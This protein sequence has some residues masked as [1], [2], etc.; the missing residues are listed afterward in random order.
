MTILTENNIPYTVRE[1]HVKRISWRAILM[2]LFITISVSMLLNLLGLGL[3]FISLIP[4]L[5]GLKTV[6][7]G[8]VIWIILS[9]IISIYI[10]AW[11]AGREAPLALTYETILHGFMVWALDFLLGIVL[12]ASS[13]GMLTGGI[14]SLVGTSLSIAGEATATMAEKIS[15]VAPK[16]TETVKNLFSNEAAMLG[17]IQDQAK[18][19]LT[20]AQKKLK[21][22]QKSVA[23]EEATKKLQGE[24]KNLISEY[25]SD[26]Q[27][28]DTAAVE[29]ALANFLVKNSNMSEEKA[30]ATIEG[31]KE[32]Y[33][34]LKEKTN[35]KVDE[36]QQK[37]GGVIENANKSIGKFALLSFFI[38]LLGAVAGGLGGFVGGKSRKM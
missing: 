38:M 36:A 27:N 23:N 30:K 10:G 31:W 7:T 32:K 13:I 19:V 24:L 20:T 26:N 35:Q 6:A 4:T 21:A 28:V 9:S 25:F 8:A 18:D 22:A 2:G 11:V 1:P 16:A 3:G 29:D 17:Q 12:V 5:D 14:T 34:S 37:I 15:M 33:D